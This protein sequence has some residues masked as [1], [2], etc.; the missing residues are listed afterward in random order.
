M[1]HYFLKGVKKYEI[2]CIGFFFTFYLS[3]CNNLFCVK[4]IFLAGGQCWWLNLG[5][6]CARQVP[7]YPKHCLQA[8]TIIKH[9]CFY[10]AKTSPVHQAQ[11]MIF[12]VVF[13]TPLDGCSCFQ[14]LL[15]GVVLQVLESLQVNTGWWEKD[16]QTETK[17]EH[18]SKIVKPLS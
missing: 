6:P 2:F 14:P 8:L 10:F 17:R 3:Y 5:W 18:L 4:I 16:R 7:P 13:F 11:T 12:V 9:Q 15:W 1:S